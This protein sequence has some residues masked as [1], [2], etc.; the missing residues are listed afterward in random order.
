MQ[1]LMPQLRQLVPIIYLQEQTL[2]DAQQHVSPR[3]NL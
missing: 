1:L 3:I 2:V